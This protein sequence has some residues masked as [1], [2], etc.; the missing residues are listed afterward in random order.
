MV[1][2]LLSYGL[3]IVAAGLIAMSVYRAEVAQLFQE[4]ITRDMLQQ[5]AQNDFDMGVAVGQSFPTI[6]VE[7]NDR[8]YSSLAAF[9]E[10]RG[11]VLVASRSVVWCPFCRRYMAQLNEYADAFAE[12]GIGLVALTY[13]SPEDQAFFANAGSI[14]YPILSDVNAYSVKA[15]GILHQGYEEGDAAYGIPHPGVYIV[16]RRN[17]I[18]DKLFIDDYTKRID[19]QVILDTAVGLLY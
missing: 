2:A 6:R 3:L 12:Q 18:V 17:K 10:R 4:L 8:V 7:Y 5:E 1:R 16:D 15:L 13:D 9:K 19:P 11:T 14:D